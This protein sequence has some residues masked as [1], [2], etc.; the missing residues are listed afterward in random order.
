MNVK[1]T[2][3]NI[4]LYLQ[5]ARFRQL[6]FIVIKND[7]IRAYS[8]VVIKI[9]LSRDQDPTK[10]FTAGMYEINANKNSA[11]EKQLRDAGGVA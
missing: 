2:K 9:P 1:Q 3:N 8:A 10:G 7:Y 4:Y 6:K 5:I 11:D